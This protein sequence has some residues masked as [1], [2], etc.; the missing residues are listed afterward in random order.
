MG[1][2]TAVMAVVKA[3][4]YGHGAVQAAKAAIEGGATWL[5]V[6]SVQEGIELRRVGLTTPILNLGYTP[7]VALSAAV[8][9]NLSLTLYDRDSLTRL[10]S[11]AT[12]VGVHVKVD[13]GMHRL[14]A[15]QTDAVALATEVHRD[16]R[17]RLEGFWTHFSSA[18][19][20]PEFTRDQLR[21]FLEAR[22]ALWAGGVT[23]FLS[24]A[25]NS[26]GLLRLPAARLD[27][28]RAGLVI[29]GVRPVRAG[30]DLP[31]LRP[32]MTWQTIVT[33]VQAVEP[34]ETVGYGRRFT[35]VRPAKIA[36]I[37]VGY[38]DGLHRQSSAGAR[39]L[40]RGRAVPFAGTISMD[41]AA[42]D[43]TS[44]A[45]VTAGDVVTLIGRDGEATATADDLAEAA[46]TISYEVLC[47]ISGRVPRR[48]R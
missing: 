34:G 28:V 39:A 11:A 33:R 31:G 24:H 13:T 3:N 7:P 43:V 14:G 17:L 48:Y 2:A 45:D 23:G 19:D 22:A 40:V 35:A 36:T 27:L 12:E 6:S 42:L 1:D 41:Q 30:D 29:Y 18:D 26:A 20:D 25:A 46:G 32:A 5:G 16:P 38:A 9:A 21:R 15:G 37:A 44:V 4:G 10:K 47:A 8:A